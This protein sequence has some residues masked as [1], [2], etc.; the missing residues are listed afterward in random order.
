MASWRASLC[1]DWL[2]KRHKEEAL[3]RQRQLQPIG[4]FPWTAGSLSVPTGHPTLPGQLTGC[5]EEH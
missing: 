5:A 3:W 1:T 4:L 2:M